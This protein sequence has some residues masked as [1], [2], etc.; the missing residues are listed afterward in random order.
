MERDGK[1]APPTP[2]HT[3]RSP[4]LSIDRMLDTMRVGEPTIME[5]YIINAGCPERLSSL[6]WVTQQRSSK[7]GQVPGGWRLSV[8]FWGPS[9]C[10]VASLLPSSLPLPSS[11]SLTMWKQQ[12]SPFPLW[13]PQAA[14]PS[15]HFHMLTPCSGRGGFWKSL[16][17][18]EPLQWVLP[19]GCVGQQKALSYLYPRSRWHWPCFCKTRVGREQ[20]GAQGYP[21]AMVWTTGPPEPA[22]IISGSLHSRAASVA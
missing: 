22:G 19:R 14:L 18:K 6:S 4:S 13:G 12:S 11:I 10:H 15:L 21:A 8:C 17:Y 9:V 2:A 16:G 1:R 7:L 3:V 20:C 5:L